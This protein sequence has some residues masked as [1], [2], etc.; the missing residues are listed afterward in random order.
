MD[1]IS[2]LKELLEI[3]FGNEEIKQKRKRKRPRDSR[4]RFI[5]REITW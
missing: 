3:I 5:K 2:I 1:D 4:G